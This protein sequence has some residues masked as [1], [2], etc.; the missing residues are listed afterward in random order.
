[1]RKPV[2]LILI[3]LASGRLSLGQQVEL[4]DT[5]RVCR[6]DS[7]QVSAGTDFDT[8]LWNTGETTNS[9]WISQTGDYW[10]N[11]TSGDTVD[12]TANLY[13]VN[14]PAALAQD[15][16]DLMCGDTIALF[17]DT[18]GFNAF[19]DPPEVQGDTL[20]VFPRDTTTYV[21][22]I[23]DPSNPFDYCT[24]SVPV[25]VEPRIYVDTLDQ[26]TMGCPGEDVAQME[27]EATGDYEPLEYDW[28]A[29]FQDLYN[30]NRVGGL[31]DGD[32]YV[33]I[34]DT[35]GCEHREDFTVEAFPLPEIELYTDKTD[36]DGN[37]VVYLQNPS[38]DFYYENISFDSLGTD[39]FQLSTW[40]WEFGDETA[41][42]LPSPTHLY[43][44]TGMFDVV[45]NYTTFYNCVS[46]DSMKVEVKPVKLMIPNVITP[47]GDGVNDTFVIDIDDGSGEEG[48]GETFKNGS[49][50]IPDLNEYYIS[51]TLVIFNRWGQQL[52]EANNYENDWDGEDLVDGA[53]FYVLKC[54]GQYRDDVYKGSITILRNP[55]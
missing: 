32:Y 16:T 33:V 6:T 9:I 13:F 44:S 55:F 51:N 36:E 27:V 8:Y 24:D 20:I 10:V 11:V 22:T 42:N 48:G 26:L 23:S 2:F 14:F 31:T 18:V 12:I 52:F 37:T 46:T 15:A 43:K 39:T 3:L 17:V 5:L 49:D 28:S 45:F 29:G 54:E 50:D 40:V 41:S 35:L 1:M 30:P 47:N 4:P 25:G 53:Y 38:L 7:V 21:V 19:W 34:S